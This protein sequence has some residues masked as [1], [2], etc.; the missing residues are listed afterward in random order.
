M[1]LKFNAI[2]LSAIRFANKLKKRIVLRRNVTVFLLIG[3]IAAIAG[4]GCNKKKDANKVPSKNVGI[5][6][7]Y[8]R[9]PVIFTISVSNKEITIADR[10]Q[11]KLEV[12]AKEEYEVLLPEFGEKLQQFGIV[13]YSAPPPQLVEDG[14]IHLS[15]TYELEPFLSGDYKIPPMKVRFWKKGEKKKH[16]LESEELTIHVK[17]ILPEKAAD[18]KIKEIMPPVELPRQPLWWLYGI[19]GAT[20]LGG[21]GIAGFLLWRKRRVKAEILL[22]RPAHEIAY[23]DLEILLAE[24]LI[25]KGEVKFFY[26]RLSNILRHYIENRFGLHAPEQTTEEFLMAI[27][28]TDLLSSTHKE[29]LKE[30]LQHCDLVKF[31][32]HTPATEEIQKTFDGCK[33]FIAETKIEKE[34]E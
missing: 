22:Q 25:E 6:K 15:K 29:L 3:M 19:I 12:R 24:N 34:T 31:A 32:E 16:T 14:M 18:L 11:L 20:V 9:G 5:E 33:Q 2:N 7:E 4:A 8:K 23:E 17:S 28:S 21:V 10:L 30:F 26:L 1:E 27:R 13:D